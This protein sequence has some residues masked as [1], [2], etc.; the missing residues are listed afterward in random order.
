LW[1]HGYDF[2]ALFAE[3]YYSFV[4]TP[5]DRPVVFQHITFPFVGPNML[6]E[7]V[8]CYLVYTITSPPNKEFSVTLPTPDAAVRMK[9]NKLVRTAHRTSESLQVKRVKT[10]NFLPRNQIF[11]PNRKMGRLGSDMMFSDHFLLL[12]LVFLLSLPFPFFM[13]F[14]EFLEKPLHFQKFFSVI[15]PSVASTHRKLRILASSTVKV[16]PVFLAT[17]GANINILNARHLN[18]PKR[19]RGEVFA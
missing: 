9:L 16:I 4:I 18:H 3:P 12:F 5:Y 13:E 10:G 2:I 11:H 15:S 8:Y 14:F 1:F 19:K 17:N 7:A 6:S